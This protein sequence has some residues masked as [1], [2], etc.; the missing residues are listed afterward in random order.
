MMKALALLAVFFMSETVRAQDVHFSQ[1][2]YTPL[3]VN[4]AMTGIFD[5]K[6]RV[7]NDYRSQ[8]SGVGDGYKTIHVSLDMPVGKTRFKNNYFGVGLMVYQDNAGS[9]K[10]SHTII[11]GA[12]A[13]TT[14][15]DDGDNYLSVGFRG[16][17][18]SR[19]VDF[20]RATWASQWNGDNYDPTLPGESVQLQQRTY[21]D[22]TAG[23]M[24]YYIPDGINSISAG[25]SMSHITKPDL[26][27]SN[28]NHDYL[29]NLIAI[30]AGAELSLDQNNT[31]WVAP[32]F[33][34]QFQGNQKEIL[35]GT[36]MKQ[37][38]QLKSKY[39]NYR[40]DTYFSYGAWYRF[41]DA[42]IFAA[43]IDYNDFGLG[44]SYD[45]TTSDFPSLTGASG[46]PE[47]SLSYIPGIRRGQRSKHFNKMPKYF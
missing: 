45:L 23:L 20:S 16:G 36:F 28:N 19:E 15:V 24:W 34:V 11:E 6:V 40:Y 22:F 25:G 27:F 17:L 31:F 21:F 42:F 7:S 37:K 3:M 46:G 8:W 41:G 10:F 33:L 26:S 38:L 35:P 12:L 5:G 1:F 13:Y 30:H 43:R 39:T 44:I 4:P 9:A 29:N 32:K 14:S 18:D 2:Y 47:F